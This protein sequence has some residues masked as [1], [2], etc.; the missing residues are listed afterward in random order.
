MQ[1]IVKFI[2]KIS[3]EGQMNDLPPEIYGF[4]TMQDAD[5]KLMSDVIAG[6][7][8]RYREMGGMVVEKDQGAFVNREITWLG[9]MF[10]PFE[11]IVRITVALVNLSQEISLPDEKGVERLVDGT[12]LVKN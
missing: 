10:V 5:N 8:G 1:Q 3:F 7:F 11:W 2:G 9:H 12:E 6:Q 4:V